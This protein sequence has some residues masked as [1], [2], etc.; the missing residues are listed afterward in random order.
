MK[1]ETREHVEAAVAAGA[2][3]TRIRKPPV[4][5]E[6]EVL[7]GVAAAI[8]LLGLEIHRNNTGAARLP[9]RGGKPQLVRFGQAGAGDFAGWL[10]GGRHVEIEVK[11]PGQRPRPEQLARLVRIN[12]AGGVGFWVD[13]AAVAESI[14]R[15]VAAGAY[16][17]IDDRG[18]QWVVRP[19]SEHAS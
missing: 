1:P 10:P 14:L 19:D 2:K 16:V 9:G 11:R 18:R 6:R 15:H 7:A 4:P 12:A 17:V 5:L 13:D 3:A 8:A